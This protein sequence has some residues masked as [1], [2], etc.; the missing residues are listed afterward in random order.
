MGCSSKEMGLATDL[1]Y[2][3]PRYCT[4]YSNRIS[5]NELTSQMVASSVEWH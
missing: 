5:A 1:Y 3:S 4:A 2:F